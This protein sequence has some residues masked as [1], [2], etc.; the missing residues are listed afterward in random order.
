[1]SRINKEKQRVQN[2]INDVKASKPADSALASNIK[3]SNDDVLKN[4]KNKI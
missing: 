4:L 1:M 3:D 2:I